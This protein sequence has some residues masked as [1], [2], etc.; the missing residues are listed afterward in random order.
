[1]VKINGPHSQRLPP[2]KNAGL[3]AFVGCAERVFCHSTGKLDSLCLMEWSFLSLR[4]GSGMKAS[5]NL[6][7]N[8]QHIPDKI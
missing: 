1:M 2:H 6:K 4:D 7:P 8:N 5:A 3:P